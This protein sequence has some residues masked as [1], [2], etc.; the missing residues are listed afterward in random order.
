MSYPNRP[1]YLRE[2][3]PPRR[4]EPTPVRMIGGMSIGIALIG[5]TGFVAALAGLFG[6]TT[7]TI[8]AMALGAIYGAMAGRR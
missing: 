2:A 3:R 7:T 4:P 1:S 8:G 6:W 5:V